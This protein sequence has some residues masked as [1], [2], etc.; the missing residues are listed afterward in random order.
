MKIAM[1]LI[2]ESKLAVDFTHSNFIGIYDV[3][4]GELKMF[5][6]DSLESKLKAMDF[7]KNMVTDGL[8]YTISPFYSYM[9]LKIFKENNIK[10][11]K[12]KGN[13]LNENIKSFKNSALCPF[14]LEESLLYGECAKDCTGCGITCSDN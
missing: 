4:E 3:T 11:L 5:S 12:S 6:N 9:T 8:V 13:D 14:L 10:A 7:I 2:N 1:P